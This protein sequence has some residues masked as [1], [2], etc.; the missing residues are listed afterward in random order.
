MYC[1]PAAVIVWTKP[2]KCR[3]FGNVQHLLYSANDRTLHR[4]PLNIFPHDQEKHNFVGL[5]AL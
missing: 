3:I 1:D 2:H 4:N 5:M